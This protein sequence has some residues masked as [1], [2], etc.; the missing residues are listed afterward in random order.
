M[1]TSVYCLARVVILIVKV[2]SRLT[3]AISFCCLAM[4]SVI[5]IKNRTNLFNLVS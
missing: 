3:K 1:F 4:S 5:D 2:M